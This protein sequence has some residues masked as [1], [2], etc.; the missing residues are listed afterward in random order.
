MESRDEV[1]QGAP[2]EGSLKLIGLLE[3]DTAL[4]AWYSK[5]KLVVNRDASSGNRAKELED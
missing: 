2:W 4:G 1:K 3:G 5:T